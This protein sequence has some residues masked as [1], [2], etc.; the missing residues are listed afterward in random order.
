MQTVLS[1]R[2]QVS[3]PEKDSVREE[4]LRLSLKYNFVTPLTSMVVTKP[5]GDNTDV[6]NKPV[7]GQSSQTPNR[8]LEFGH[9]H[10]DAWTSVNEGII[11][12][13]VKCDCMY[14]FFFINL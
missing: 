1:Y 5:T 7:E 11:G 2:L 8:S 12:H 9:G 10:V 4:A 14:L 3:G 6:L 13:L